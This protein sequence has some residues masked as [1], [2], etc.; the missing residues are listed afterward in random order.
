I[1]KRLRI[2]NNPTPFVVK[3][4]IKDFHYNSLHQA[5]QPA[6]FMNVHSTNL[7]RFLS[8]KLQSSN[9]NASLADIQQ[10]WSELLP[11]T[12]FDY[13]FQDEALA[14]MYVR[15]VRLQKA[16]YAATI[17]AI[18]IALLGVFGLLALSIQKRIREIGIRKV[19]GAKAINIIALFLK[20]FLPVLGIA[21]LLACPVA[22]YFARDWLE[23]YSYR[24]SLSVLPF[25]STLLIL[26][27]ATV[28]LIALQSFKA[29]TMNPV[30]AIRQE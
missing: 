14:D 15:E 6:V 10:K 27:G 13:Q 29:S 21:T 11:T 28:L 12:P 7:Y 16:A 23:G 9:I 5:I 22:W 1:Q 30:D 2:V 19:I 4:I 24:I 3:G 17:L 20:D 8:F 25:L 26:G 18:I